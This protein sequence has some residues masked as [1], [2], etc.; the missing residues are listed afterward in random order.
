V[1]LAGLGDWLMAQGLDYDSDA[2]RATALALFE[3]ARAAVGD[4]RLGLVSDPELALRLGARLDAL[5]GAGP[6]ALAEAADGEIQRVL[7]D[8]A[9]RGLAALGAPRDEVA[10]WLLGARSLAEAPGAGRRALLA[11]GFTTHEIEAAE[12]EL[13]FVPRLADAFRPAV[14]GDGFVRDVLGATPEQL[15]DPAL[16]VLALAGFAEADV[17]EA[18]AHALGRDSLAEA[19][20]LSEAQRRAL[21]GASEIDPGAAAAMLAAL[22]PAL[23]A[24][25]VLQ[26][27][28]PWDAAPDAV[29]LD[30]RVAARVRR[31]APPAA[32]ALELPVVADLPARR[33]T[34]EPPEERIIERIVERERTRRKLPDRRKGYIQKTRVGGHKVYL[35]TG[36]YDDGEL[37]E[38]FIDM[39][40]E[41]AAF[42]SLMN[43]FAIAVSLGLQHGVPLEEFVDAFVFTRFEPAGPVTGN[44]SVKS[45]PRSST[46]SSASWGSAI[47]AARTWP[48]PTRASS[49][50]TAWARARPRRSRR[51]IRSRFRTSSPAAFRAARRRTTW[52]SCRPRAALPAPRRWTPRRSARPAA[53]SPSCA[54]ARPLSAIPAGLALR[55]YLRTTPAKSQKLPRIKWRRV[56]VQRT[57]DRAN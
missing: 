10:E 56:G 31:D 29:P 54:K 19:E 22:A 18:E 27:S 46:T 38:I 55:V 34:V 51:P 44:D 53:I 1:A 13:P 49:T 35:H 57:C 40:K 30:A 8:A 39:H 47:W 7:S 25:P 26:V 52:C 24:P 48:T 45:R 33:E 5:P 11:R 23:D 28:L 50:P 17:L 36:E 16:D 20:F 4:A 43:N 12:A 21:R 14:I 42:R 9:L 37:G 15:A 2:G 6:V 3:A 41:G 32:A